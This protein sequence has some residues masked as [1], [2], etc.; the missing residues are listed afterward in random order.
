MEEVRKVG[1]SSS[2]KVK[3]SASMYSNDPSSSRDN[4]SKL[5]NN[6]RN[7]EFFNTLDK[8]KLKKEFPPTPPSDSPPVSPKNQNDSD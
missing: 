7:S 5:Q 4:K 3:N 6:Y 8:Q 1:H 2:L